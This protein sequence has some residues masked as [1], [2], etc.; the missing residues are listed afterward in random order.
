MQTGADGEAGERPEPSLR[1]ILTRIEAIEDRIT[2]VSDSQIQRGQA[3]P[4][5]SALGLS[6]NRT[7][8]VLDALSERSARIARAWAGVP[9]TIGVVVLVVGISLLLDAVFATD[10]SSTAYAHGLWGGVALIGVGAAS[11]TAASMVAKPEAGTPSGQP[12]PLGRIGP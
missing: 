9:A 7:L 8:D 11:A 5:A 1:H 2:A 3:S 12:N 4:D 10:T 6:Y